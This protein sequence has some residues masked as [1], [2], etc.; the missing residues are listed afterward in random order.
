MSPASHRPFWRVR[1]NPKKLHRT[2]VHLE[3]LESRQLLAIVTWNNPSG[4]SWDVARNW[5]G[6]TTGT[7]L[8][9]PGDDVVI[10]IAVTNPI[11]I[12][13]NVESVNSV[14]CTE[15]LFISGGGLSVGAD[16]TISGGLNITGGSLTAS[17]SG[18]TLTVTGATTVS[19]A[20]LYAQRGAS[21]TMPSLA[22]YADGANYITVLQAS[23]T[24][25]VLS[26][27]KL[28]T[29]T[30]NGA[31]YDAVAQIQALS[32]GDVEL[33]GLT[34]LSG[35]PVQFESDGNPGAS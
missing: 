35:G 19:G 28:A 24:G 1:R 13:T 5:S 20:N 21:L 12:T 29:V 33:P 11:A 26:F 6:S 2:R 9:G 32:G 14:T 10:N 15:P 34:Q 4:G 7:G 30:L 23:G 3:Q 27:P 17:G 25:S 31:S 18:V 16:S 22:S 8:P